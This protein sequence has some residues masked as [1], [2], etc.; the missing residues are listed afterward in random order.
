MLTLTYQNHS[1]I[2]VEVEG[3]VPEALRG[4]SVA[5]IERTKILH[6]NREVPLAEL[7][8]VS[9]SAED[10][11]ITF[12]GDLAG[13]H[14]IG[15]KQRL[16]VIRVEGDAGRHL[17]SE[18]D[19]GTIH[20]SGDAGDFPGTEMRSGLIHVRGS[21]GNLAGGAYR[22]SARGMT[23]GTLLIGGDAGHE[24]GSTMRRG[25]I[26]VGGNVGDLAAFNMIAGTVLVMGAAGQRAAAGMRRGTL[27][28][29]G[30]TQ[31][32]LP[33]F[34]EAGRCRPTYMR[35]YAAELQRRDFRPP[36][37]FGGCEWQQFTGDLLTVGKGEVLVPVE[38]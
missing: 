36:A 14:W 8:R 33:T 6:G 24:V 34:R 22:G 13:V 3:I 20:V 38:A 15:A 9:G 5:E 30:G 18:L 10:E 4:R 35:L 12:V 25:L 17:G 16:G 21:V 26:A 23:G 1:S 19:G 37:E 31:P 28:V 32:L 27:A 29:L 2:P 7:F 11:Q